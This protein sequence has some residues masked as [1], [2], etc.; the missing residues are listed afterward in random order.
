[1]SIANILRNKITKLKPGAVFCANDFLDLGSRGNIDVILHR[2]ADSGVIRKLGVGLYD[3]PITSPILGD[4]TPDIFTAIK[5]YMRRTGHLIVLDPLGA[6]NTLSLT[7]QVPAQMTFLTN[8]KSHT[9]Q[10]CGVDIKFIH[11]APKKLAGAGTSIDVI[12]QALHYFGNKVIPDRIIKRIATHLS[13]KDIKTLKSVRNKTL[14][15]ITPQ[16]DR[17]I[18]NAS[19][20]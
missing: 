8:G 18:L 4:L 11:A 20:N 12:I 14:Q 10:I 7:N 3:K 16:I 6:A 9:I 1:M 17:I 19:T 2:L 15:Y 5:A 13:H